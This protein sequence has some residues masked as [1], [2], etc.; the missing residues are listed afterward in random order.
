LLAWTFET[1]YSRGAALVGFIKWTSLMRWKID[2]KCL[3]MLTFTARARIEEAVRKSSTQIIV[4][5]ALFIGAD[6]VPIGPAA[7]QQTAPRCPQ[8]TASKYP[9][10]NT[11]VYFGSVVEGSGKTRNII[12]CVRIE[13]AQHPYIVNWPDAEW[14]DA[15]TRRD[16]SDGYLE[17]SLPLLRDAELDASEVTIGANQRK[18]TPRIL[19][20]IS[21]IQALLQTG[22]MFLT[23]Y[24][25]SI[26]IK[27][28]AP[29]V[30]GNFIPVN[31]VFKASYTDGM[32]RL[33]Y[34]ND[35]RDNPRTVSF[36]VSAEVR[37]RIPE[38]KEKYE[39]SQTASSTEPYKIEEPPSPQR[40]AIIFINS[41][42]QE[43]ATIPVVIYAP[44]RR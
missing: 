5:T 25:G 3:R 18:F 7:A 14:H 30:A 8:M 34:E 17:S 16:G 35:E 41:D 19:K 15:A 12:Y 2:L 27:P 29:E 9:F 38:W 23:R 36:K 6:A 4:L 11:D 28:N 13:K 37:E 31:L 24:F 22:E 1:T 42:F 10:D 43:V 26:P 39:I 44:A 32:G 20:E 40:I 33:E 21:K